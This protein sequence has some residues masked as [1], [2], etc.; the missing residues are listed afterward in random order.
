MS[1]QPAVQDAHACRRA[2]QAELLQFWNRN[3]KFLA[4]AAV[5]GVALLSVQSATAAANLEMKHI[6]WDVIGLDHNMP[7][8]DGPEDFPVAVRVKNTGDASAPN[9]AVSLKLEEPGGNHH[10]NI[11]GKNTITTPSLA[12]GQ[13]ADFYF[14]VRIDRPTG[15]TNGYFSVLNNPST[16]RKYWFEASIDGAAPTDT[17]LLNRQLFVEGIISQNRNS[18][19]PSLVVNDPEDPFVPGQIRTFTLFSDTATG[20][21]QQ[22]TG[23]NFPTD[24]FQIL[25]VRALYT[26]P[27]CA[28]QIINQGVFH[29]NLELSPGKYATNKIYVDACGWITDPNEPGYMLPN[30][31][32]GT[33]VNKRETPTGKV[34]GTIVT[35]FKVKILA[36]ILDK[37]VLSYLVHDRSGN[38]FHYNF[39]SNIFEISP[40]NILVAKSAPLDPVEAKSDFTYMITVMNNSGSPANDVVL[41]DT[42][43]SCVEVKS[44]SPSPVDISANPLIW[45]LGTLAPGGSASIEVTANAGCGEGTCMNTASVSTI[46]QETTYEDTES[47]AEVTIVGPT[48]TEI[49]C[50]ADKTLN[51]P[52]DTSVEAN[53]T[54]TATD[55]CGVTIDHDDTTSA[56]CGNSF[57]LFRKWTATDDAGNVSQCTQQ[58]T[59]EDTTAPTLSDVTDAEVECGASTLPSDT[60]RPQA[61]DTC[62]DVEVTYVDGPLS[63]GCGST[64]SFTRT[65]TATDECGNSVSTEQLITIVDTTPPNLQCPANIT[66]A[67]PAPGQTCTVVNYPNVVASD[68]CG[69]VTIT[70]DPPSGTCFECGKTSVVTVTATDECNNS[71]TC[72]FTVT[73]GNCAKPTCGFTQGYWKNHPA[74]WP[75]NSL[76]LGTTQY[77]KTQLLAILNK[78]VKGNALVSLAHQLIAA[79]LNIANGADDNCIAS[80]IAAADALIGNKLIPPVGS[81]SVPNKQASPLI[82][83]LDA[84]NNGLL[85]IS[86]CDDLEPLSTSLTT[87]G[88]GKKN[89]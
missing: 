20:Y 48:P 33:D 81:K 10:I 22:E 65:W 80:T 59:V 45:N 1:T 32:C 76:V 3:T 6:T 41:S 72:T 7:A 40:T 87:K 54:A 8:T 82:N 79:K 86:H 75:V 47:T 52:G 38:S 44:A 16:V 64:G 53:G 63:D 29:E 15:S 78:P 74:A 11:I 67:S 77:S 70:Y 57:V 89:R 5:S 28:C 49:D 25:S 88:K 13:M 46:D 85:C 84:Y 42:L 55:A 18:V 2:W 50:P 26:D 39:E 24:I 30:G 23:I 21:D 31:S 34:G 68:T 36:P 4:M 58:L 19:A 35:V 9:V 60:G 61:E 17:K 43:P 56:T 71:R 14:Q 12:A 69:I 27:A 73:V 51:C 83:K 37:V 62:G 66:A